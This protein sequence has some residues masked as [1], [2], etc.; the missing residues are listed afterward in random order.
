[1]L[2]LQ[3][4]RTLNLQATLNKFPNSYIMSD[5]KLSIENNRVVD[6]DCFDKT[7]LVDIRESGNNLIIG[8]YDNNKFIYKGRNE[9][10]PDVLCIV[11]KEW[12]LK[13]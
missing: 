13:E 4:V 11:L 7:Y 3:K 8:Q 5:G 6:R 10:V 1:M 12:E 2:K 9:Y